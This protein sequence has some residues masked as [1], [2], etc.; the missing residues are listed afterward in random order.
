MGRY[1]GS[2][3]V[4]V[5]LA[6]G[7]ADSGAMGFARMFR[8]TPVKAPHGRYVEVATGH[9]G[10]PGLAAGDILDWVKALPPPR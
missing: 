3:R 8:Q 1:V 2:I 10:T 7:T 9:G 6:V 5:L 4:P